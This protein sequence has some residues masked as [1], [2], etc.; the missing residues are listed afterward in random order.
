MSGKK[1]TAEE[2]IHV[3][4]EE[5]RGELSVAQLC[6]RGGHHPAD[7]LPVLEGV[8]GQAESD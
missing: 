1:F 8:S 4:L 7:V 3:V 6:R 5:L 2:K